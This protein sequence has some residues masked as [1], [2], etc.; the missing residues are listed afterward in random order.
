M[1]GPE[2]VSD[3]LSYGVV[4]QEVEA[5]TTGY[6]ELMYAENPAAYM[7]MDEHRSQI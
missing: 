4:E 6:V 2:L 1:E 5:R 7:W 3:G